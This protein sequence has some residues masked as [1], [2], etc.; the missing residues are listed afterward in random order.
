ME[1]NWAYLSKSKV[2]SPLDPASPRLGGV[3]T[4]RF[5]CVSKIWEKSV[6][7]GYFWGLGPEG[8]DGSCASL[9]VRPYYAGI[10]TLY[11]Y[12][13]KILMVKR[14]SEHAIEISTYKDTFI[15]CALRF[16]YT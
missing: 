4:D 13:F 10:F 16:F 1:D 14:K 15:A 11:I 2:H 6:N 12:Y 5:T 9:S 7:A 3:P 8:R